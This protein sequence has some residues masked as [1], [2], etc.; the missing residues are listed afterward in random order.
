[1]AVI[2]PMLMIGA[3]EHLVDR[4]ETLFDYS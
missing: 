3:A 4:A 2:E 1:M